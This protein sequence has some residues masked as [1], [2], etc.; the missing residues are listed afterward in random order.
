MRM[1]RRCCGG[2]ISNYSIDKISCISPSF[3]MRAEAKEEIVLCPKTE[4]L[5]AGARE[6]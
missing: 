1:C 6:R 5:P 2:R 3:K 4:R